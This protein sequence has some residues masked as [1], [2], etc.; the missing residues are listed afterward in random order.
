MTAVFLLL[1]LVAA[2]APV[3]VTGRVTD[4]TGA[5]VAAAIH[6]ASA[7][8][9]VVARRKPAAPSPSTSTPCAEG[10]GVVAAGFAS[11]RFGAT[12]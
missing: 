3:R 1:S 2:A 4:S 11:E 8:G 7:D 10:V 5:P 12:S 9:P 6:A